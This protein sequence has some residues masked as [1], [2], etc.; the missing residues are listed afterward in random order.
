[1]CE[2]N[3]MKVFVLTSH[4]PLLSDYLKTIYLCGDK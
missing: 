2:E 3:Q 4:V 1:M